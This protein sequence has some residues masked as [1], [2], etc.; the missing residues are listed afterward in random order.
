MLTTGSKL[1][2]GVAA[3]ALVGAWIYGLSTGGDP[4]GVLSACFIFVLG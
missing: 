3:A 2:F 4:V 1:F